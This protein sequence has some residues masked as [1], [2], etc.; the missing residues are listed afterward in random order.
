[1]KTKHLQFILTATLIFVV[2]VS[3]AVDI[4][5]SIR[6]LVTDLQAGDAKT[7]AI[8][9][10][11]LPNHGLVVVPAM[12]SILN[13]NDP[14]LAK[15]AYDII[16]QVVNDVSVPGRDKDRKKLTD[17]LMPLLS[18]DR[19]EKER[20]TGLRFLD[21]LVPPGYDVAPIAAMLA[22]PALC[23][24]A[25]TALQRIGTEEAQAALSSA[26][27]N[28]E[29]AFQV[30]LLN[31]LGELQDGE[32]L[33]VILRLAVTGAPEVQPAA[34]RALAWTG[35]P[36]YL[37]TA[38]S[39]RENAKDT[40]N[41]DATDA[42][43]RLIE[44]VA[45][46]GGNWDISVKTYEEIAKTSQGSYRDAALTALGKIGDERHVPLLMEAAQ[47]AGP[48]TSFIA[49]SALQSLQ[50]PAVTRRLV[51]KL[52]ELDIPTQ[53]ALLPVLA[54]R[55][56]EQTVPA[57]V[58][59]SK[60][61][62]AVLRLVGIKALGGAGLTGGVAPLFEVVQQGSAE[63]KAAAMEALFQLGGTLTAH[64]AKGDAAGIYIKLWGLAPDATLKVRAL[65]GLNSAAVPE[66]Y[67]MAMAAAD[68]PGL[69]DQAISALQAV[70]GAL[71]A[72]GQG[73]KAVAAYKKMADL[74]PSGPALQAVT[75]GLKGLSPDM[76]VAE[77]V[78]FIT[79]WWVTGPFPLGETKEGWD[80]TF[81][82][83]PNID[84][85]ATYTSG[86]VKMSWKKVVG[87]NDIGKVDLLKEVANCNSCLGYAYTEF[88]AGEEVDVILSLGVDDGEK[89]WFNGEQVM[90]NFMMG[91]L[92]VDRDKI[93]VHLKNGKNT[94]L[95]KIFQNAMPWEFC[96][97]ILTPEG[98]PYLVKQKSE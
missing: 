1:M 88:E 77:M 7:K 96:V 12:L 17:M 63:D 24:K 16:L 97:R 50:G 76:N 57:L 91:G 51:V 11:L 46:K 90:N 5:P 18:K 22:E 72:A 25:R 23:E 44:R 89:V 98:V 59:A 84:L 73:E 71:V 27:S 13:G 9:R 15:A 65:Q 6:S 54:S 8:A 28:A 58:A 93:K 82:S 87:T 69:R 74:H 62:D 61:S 86:D 79:N 78:G 75:A 52:P 20:I 41:N 35:N 85:A 14:A 83:E 21:R 68:D 10:Q 29:P 92:T 2:T 49:L 67:D 55:S 47:T 42:L 48:P 26:L 56:D 36:T 64:G 30:A 38:R 94:I 33:E 19:A 45:Q 31:S 80:T 32:S 95:L 3:F 4:D 81:V 39:V 43:L 66:G 37:A 60:S 34:I 70:A 53:M 40:L